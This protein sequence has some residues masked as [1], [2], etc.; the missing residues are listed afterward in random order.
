MWQQWPSLESPTVTLQDRGTAPSSGTGTRP[1][2][3]SC[4]IPPLTRVCGQAVT[5]LHVQLQYNDRFGNTCTKSQSVRIT[6]VSVISF[7]FETTKG[8]FLYKTKAPPL[9]MEWVVEHQS[10]GGVPAQLLA[11]ALSP[12]ASHTQGQHGKPSEEIQ[13]PFVKG[14]WGWG[15]E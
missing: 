10:P 2:Q 3:Y 7:P 1:T 11:A 5:F 13:L 9:E 8:I 15:K 12:H 14:Q 4:K 6:A